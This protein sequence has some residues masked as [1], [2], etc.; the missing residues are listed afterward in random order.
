MLAAHLRTRGYDPFL[1]YYSVKRQWSD[2]TKSIDLPLFPGYLF[3]QI[4]LNSR[5]PVLT[6]PGVMQHFAGSPHEPLLVAALTAA[7]TEGLSGEAVETQLLEGVRHYWMVHQKRSGS[8]DETA[9]PV[10]L[11]PEE[12]ERTRQRRLVQSRLMRGP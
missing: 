10:E 11:S 2:R 4:D 6:T 8:V 5:F 9:L 1:P 12:A 3:C 7:E